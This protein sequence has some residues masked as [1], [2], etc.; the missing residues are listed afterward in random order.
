MNC[1]R[2][3]RFLKCDVISNS[4]GSVQRH[5]FLGS[6]VGQVG[7]KRLRPGSALW[8]LAW[9]SNHYDGESLKDNAF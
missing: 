5:I 4:A 1:L 3:Q 6:I 8:R 7:V 2:V 9:T